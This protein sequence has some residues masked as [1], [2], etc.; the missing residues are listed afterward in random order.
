M[1]KTY[2]AR[3]VC[4]LLA[5]LCMLAT[6]GCDFSVSSSRND[7]ET[8]SSKLTTGEDGHVFKK[9]VALTFDDGPH[10][11][12][13]KMIVDELNRYGYHATF[14]VVGNRVDGTEYNGG[15]AMDY[16]LSF[17][18]E[19]GIHGYTHMAYYNECSEGEYQQEMLLTAEAI[20]ER[21]PDYQIHL[22]R[23]IGGA[24]SNQRVE[25]SP[26]SVILWSVDS[27]DWKY[28][29]VKGDSDEVC[30]QKVDIIVNNVLRDVDDGDIIL[31]HDI[32]ESS[33]DAAVILLA[34]LYEMG[35]DVVT[36]SELLGD[37]RFPGERY[38]RYKP[39]VG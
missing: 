22:M 12:R 8:E 4:M 20:H 21:H 26:Y 13:T 35:Y 23:P 7:E 28:K 25:E 27:E 39:A 3:F 18:N 15:E 24:I 33:Y 34:R 11:V 5:M 1:L 16:A 10:N 37:E 29:Y 17:G 19:V 2:L 14:F 31:M 32:W 30:A 9:R 38:L 36:V 6:L